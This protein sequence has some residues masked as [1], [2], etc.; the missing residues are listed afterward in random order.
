MCFHFYKIA[1]KRFNKR[2]KFIIKIISVLFP[3]VGE[4]SGRAQLLQSLHVDQVL[5]L[6]A[7]T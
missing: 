6:A 4:P 7:E 3:S 1:H 2:M 5:G